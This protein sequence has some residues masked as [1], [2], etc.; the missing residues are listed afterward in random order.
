VKNWTYNREIETL[1][2]QF[3]SAFN[4]IIIKRDKQNS[5]TD[6]IKANFV[7][8]PKQRVFEVLKNPAP[9]GITLPA[10]SINISSIQRDPSRTFNKAWG[11]NIETLT[12]KTSATTDYIK[13]IK[14]PVP[15]N[16]G[17]NMTMITKYQSDMDQIISNFVPYCD[18][19]II[20]SWKLPVSQGKEYEIRTEILWSGS[21][22]LNYPTELNGNQSYRVTADTSFTIKGWLF[23]SKDLNENYKKI[24]VINSD[25]VAVGEE[26]IYSCKLIT[27]LENYE[28]D[29]VSIS[30]R[31]QPR[32]ANPLNLPIIFTQNPDKR[33]I[34]EVYG[35]HFL[36]TRA[37]YISA[38]DNSAFAVLV[39]AFDPFKYDLSLKYKYPALSG[40]PIT[41]FT[42]YTDN[43]IAFELP[44]SIYDNCKIDI[45]LENEAGYG[46]VIK[47]TNNIMRDL[48]GGEYTPPICEGLSFT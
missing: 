29:F 11:F 4:D 37:V 44:Y 20:I 43:F 28:T 45:I 32:W 17:V 35:K 30:A 36:Q 8:A 2:E 9:G 46:S 5:S 31:P 40:Y 21:I 1:L 6:I 26:D 15:I 33:P 27:D 42:V 19:Y 34:I 24:Y 25:F 41:N 3:T 10:V 7:Y 12:P 14:N 13:R 23:K 22:N 38:S 18:P 39:S 47:D 48:S 16:I